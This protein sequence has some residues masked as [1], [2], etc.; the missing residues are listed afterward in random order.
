MKLS[1][2]IY[3][4]IIAVLLFIIQSDGL[5]AKYLLADFNNYFG[6][7]YDIL[8]NPTPALSVI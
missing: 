5:E 2:H 7:Y 6:P 3:S 1:K 8:G 4:I